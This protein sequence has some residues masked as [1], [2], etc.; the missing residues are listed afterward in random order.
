MADVK[1]AQHGARRT[2]NLLRAGAVGVAAA[3]VVG[4]ILLATGVANA[5]E[6]PDPRLVTGNV[7]DCAGASLAGEI[8]FGTDDPSTDAGSGT[9]SEDGTELDVTINAGFTATGI[10]V[11]AGPD[12]NVY[13][14]PFVGLVMIED[15]VAPNVGQPG[16]IPEISHWFVCGGESD[17]ETESPSPSETPSETPSESES[18][19]GTTT[20]TPGGGG[21]LPKTGVGLTGLVLTGLALTIGGAAL[22]FF[23]RKRDGLAGDSPAS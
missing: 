12:A 1:G 3:A 9:V 2:F 5:E 16:N 4:L 11:K 21:D 23:R 8:L 14:G 10:V 22:L 15:M 19:P 13:D 20:S 17:E 6:A 18:T 7:K